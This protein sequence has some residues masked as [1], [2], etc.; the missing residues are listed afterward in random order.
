MLHALLFDLD[1][2]LS[3]TDPLHVK[4][5]QQCLAGKGIK[6]DEA[7]YRTRITGRTTPAIVKQVFPEFDAAE[8]ARFS[9]LKEATF[10]ELAGE[11]KALAGLDDL[12]DLA[13]ERAWKC[14]LVTNGSRD[15]AMFMLRSIGVDRRFDNFVFG[16]EL[17]VGK[18][19]PLP[20]RLA[21]EQLGVE[22]KQALA[23]EDS[24]TGLRSATG[25]GVRTVGVATSQSADELLTAGASFV[26]RDFTDRGLWD[27]L[28]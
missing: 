20:Y 7:F 1:G 8:V 24:I 23:F 21:L 3:D 14:A 11:L 25:A 22:A 6:V 4:A 26:I 19:D 15:N 10:R 16:E 17:H 28:G 13:H 27:F 5:W 2:T 12:L 18:P 9:D